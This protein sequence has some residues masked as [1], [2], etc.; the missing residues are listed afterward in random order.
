MA[1]AALS[2]GQASRWRM[3]ISRSLHMM[4]VQLPPHPLGA[5]STAARQQCRFHRSFPDRHSDG[6]DSRTPIVRMS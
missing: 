1:E 3:M 6:S 2:Q 5:S 4:I